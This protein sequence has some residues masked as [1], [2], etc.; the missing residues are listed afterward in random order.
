M[1]REPFAVLAVL[2]LV[3]AGCQ[4]GG[5]LEATA[6]EAT[7]TE[8]TATPTPGAST[9]GAVVNLGIVTITADACTL[10]PD[11]PVSVEAGEVTVEARNETEFRAAFDLW[12]IDDDRTFEDLV[13]H[14]EAEREAAST[15]APGIG[16]PGFV[17]G[18]ISSGIVEAGAKKPMTGRITPGTWA[19]VCLSH[20]EAVTDDPFRP[21]AVLG[22]VS[23]DPT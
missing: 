20:F 17:S 11:T 2:A 5:R 1:S 16:H 9:P 4:A 19:V 15:G 7:A 6:T 13:A 10:E 14:V 18:P 12:R 3:M 23:V 8:A 22:P 21:S